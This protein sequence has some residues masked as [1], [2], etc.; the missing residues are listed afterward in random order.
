M[1][2]LKGSKQIASPIIAMTIVLAGVYTPVG[3]ASGISGVFF[4]V[5]A[6]TLLGAVLISGFVALTLS[7]MMCAKVLTMP[8]K[9]SYGK[10]LESFFYRLQTQYQKFLSLLFR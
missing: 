9:G 10:K 3:F 2:A 1:A 7:P 4:K 5:F 6:Y 8:S